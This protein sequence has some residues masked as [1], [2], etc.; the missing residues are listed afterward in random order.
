LKNCFLCLKPLHDSW[1]AKLFNDMLNNNMQ[2]V[3]ISNYT[4]KHVNNKTTQRVLAL[5]AAEAIDYYLFFGPGHVK[6]G[7]NLS[8]VTSDFDLSGEN[9]IHIKLSHLKYKEFDQHNE[10]KSTGIYAIRK[11]IANYFSLTNIE[12][13]QF[14]LISFFIFN[15]I[16]KNYDNNNIINNLPTYNELEEMNNF[17]LYEE[18]NKDKNNPSKSYNPMRYRRFRSMQI[19]P[20]WNQGELEIFASDVIQPYLENEY[21]IPPYSVWID[22]IMKEYKKTYKTKTVNLLKIVLQFVTSYTYVKNLKFIHLFTPPSCLRRKK[23][24]KTVTLD[25]LMKC[26]SLHANKPK[27]LQKEILDAIAEEID[28]DPTTISKWIRGHR[29]YFPE[30][31]DTPMDVFCSSKENIHKFYKNYLIGH[32]QKLQ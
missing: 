29:N 22:G 5:T 7:Y 26:A 8:D 4:R 21:N 32:G 18:K 28:C 3:R 10:K 13:E 2:I 15:D 11:K 16:K 23:I 25:V 30:D 27:L 12:A 9:L 17:A 1:L 20:I 14:F 24:S 6:K 31:I 19:N